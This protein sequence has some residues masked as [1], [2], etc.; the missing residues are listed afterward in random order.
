[1][2]ARHR[3]LATS[4]IDWIARIDP[5]SNFFETVR[6]PAAWR[7]DRPFF[8]VAKGPGG[9]TVF[10]EKLPD[11]FHRRIDRCTGANPMFAVSG[12]PGTVGSATRA[13]WQELISLAGNQRDFLVWPFD[14]ELNDLLSSNKVVLAETYPRLAYAGALTRHLPAGRVNIGKTKL[15]QREHA[16]KLLERADWVRDNAVHLGDLGSVSNDEDAFDSYLTAAAVL[17]CAL[18]G[19]PLAN[20]DWIDE[21][22]E[23]SMLLAGPIDPGRRARRLVVPPS[24]MQSLPLPIA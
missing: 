19:R 24:R 1:M 13:V 2:Q 20:R 23:G 12:M 3:W 22:A 17:R 5:A 8:A 21:E 10:E 15:R 9:R 4:F 7:L 16:C 14:G 18:E 6:A 11:G